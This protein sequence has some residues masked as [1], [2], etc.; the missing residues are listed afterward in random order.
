MEALADLIG[1][2]ALGTWTLRVIDSFAGAAGQLNSWGL[3]VTTD[4]ARTG[5]VLTA[6]NPINETG[7]AVA[8]LVSGL[9]LVF[10]QPMNPAT[11]TVA[12]VK[13]LNPAGFP[14]PVLTVIP[15]AG[16]NNTR[17]LVATKQWL[18]AGNYT[19]KSEPGGGRRP[20]QR[21]RREWER[22]LPRAGRRA[23]YPS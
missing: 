4:A 16:T 12:D 21:A 17:F 10:A 5:A 18:R 1:D 20:R 13:V 11:V 23:S 6:V 19:I 2:D 15:A 8:T 7:S 3:S 9:E 14:V 22:S